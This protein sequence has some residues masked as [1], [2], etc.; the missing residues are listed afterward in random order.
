MT[1]DARPSARV[2]RRRRGGRSSNCLTV[3]PGRTSRK[4]APT[5]GAPPGYPDRTWPRHWRPSL[6]NARAPY[7][8]PRPTSLARS[9]TLAPRALWLASRGFITKRSLPFASG[10]ERSTMILPLGGGPKLIES[11]TSIPSTCGLRFRPPIYLA[12]IHPRALPHPR[13]VSEYSIQ[14]VRSYSSPDE[15]ARL[16][17]PPAAIHPEMTRTASPRPALAAAFSAAVHPFSS[18]RSK[19]APARSNA[20]RDSPRR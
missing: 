9:A 1:P 7:G 17:S 15:S 11:P 8:L 2:E 12:R 16:A 20:R 19:S 18:V 10:A 13:H 14:L 3:R 6:Q 4:Y 5:L